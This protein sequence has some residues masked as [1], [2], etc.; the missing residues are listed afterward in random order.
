MLQVTRTCQPSSWS[1]QSFPRQR[2][3]TCVGLQLN[4]LDLSLWPGQPGPL[5]SSL[6]L[7]MHPPHRVDVVKV[8]WGKVLFWH[9]A[10]SGRWHPWWLL[11]HLGLDLSLS[12]T[13]PGLQEVLLQL[14]LDVST[15]RSVC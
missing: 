7:S 13:C 2:V 3:E 6:H 8:D 10:C 12:S 14:L 15:P 1:P 9:L 4:P 11:L 5:G